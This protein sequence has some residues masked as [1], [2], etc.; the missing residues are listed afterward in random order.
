MIN[1]KV[2]PKAGIRN[3]SSNWPNAP[4]KA[5]THCLYCKQPVPNHKE[6]CVVI[7]RVVI[8][9][10]TVTYAQQVP[11]SWTEDDI[12][13][14]YQGSSNCTGHNELSFLYEKILEKEPEGFC[15]LCQ[16]THVEYVREAS[17]EDKDS[18]PEIE[19]LIEGDE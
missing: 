18:Y 12:N 11:R 1:V 16:R 7:E 13:F 19:R 2:H 4:E 14:K 3:H 8:L 17:E 15:N 6:D 5:D 10:Y 9:K